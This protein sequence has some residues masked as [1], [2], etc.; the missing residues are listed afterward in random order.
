MIQYA[1]IANGLY[2][3]APIYC[4]TPSC[5]EVQLINKADNNRS[6]FETN[7]QHQ[8]ITLMILGPLINLSSIGP[9][10]PAYGVI[11]KCWT[12]KKPLVSS[13]H[14]VWLTGM[15]QTD[16]GV[17]QKDCDEVTG[18]WIVPLSRHAVIHCDSVFHSEWHWDFCYNDSQKTW[19]LKQFYYLL[20]SH[21]LTWNNMTTWLAEPGCG[22]QISR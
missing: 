4:Y 3:D 1:Y 16:C 9:I 21:L 18:N 7:S 15:W 22:R 10:E 14:I 8:Q 2:C 5:T 13:A 19:L 11:T 12:L 17:C 6:T 20:F